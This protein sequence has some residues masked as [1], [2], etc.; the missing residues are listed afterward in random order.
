M[1]GQLIM[2]LKI[3]NKKYLIKFYNKYKENNFK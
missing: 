2:I 1:I 3:L